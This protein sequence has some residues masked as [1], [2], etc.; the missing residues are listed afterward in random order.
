MEVY[1]LEYE[2]ES[3]RNDPEIERM[4]GPFPSESQNVA[5]RLQRE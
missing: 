3:A 5:G 1:C 4:Y 2:F